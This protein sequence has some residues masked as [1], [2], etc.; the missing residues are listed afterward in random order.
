MFARGQQGLDGVGHRV[1][2][3]A[4]EN[5]AAG[6]KEGCVVAGVRLLAQHIE[7]ALA[8]DVQAVLF[9]RAGQVVTRAGEGRMAN[10]ADEAAERFSGEKKLIALGKHGGDDLRYR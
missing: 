10:G 9:A 8:V 5:P 1:V 3:A 2:A 6:V 7:A 4:G